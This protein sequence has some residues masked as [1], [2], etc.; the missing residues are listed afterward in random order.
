MD[1]CNLTWRMKT[2]HLKIYQTHRVVDMSCNMKH[3]WETIKY[4]GISLLAVN[5]SYFPTVFAEECSQYLN[6][7]MGGYFC[8]ITH[9]TTMTSMLLK[10]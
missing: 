2:Y 9:L 1:T 3:F 10:K 5:S 4:D 8:R 7:S 6:S